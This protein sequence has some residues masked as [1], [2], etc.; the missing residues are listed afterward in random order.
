M[1]PEIHRRRARRP[2]EPRQRL[3]PPISSG[4]S[5]PAKFQSEWRRRRPLLQSNELPAQFVGKFL[6]RAKSIRRVFGLQFFYRC[7]ERFGKLGI[8]FSQSLRSVIANAAQHCHRRLAA[9]RRPAGT[10]RIERAAQAKQIGAVI[11]RAALGLLGRH[12]FRRAGRGAGLRQTGVIYG[13]GQAEIGD[14]HAFNAVV[15]QDIGR[16]DIAMHEA[17][18]MSGRQTLGCLNADAKNFFHVL[19]TATPQT[20]LQRRSADEFHH[21]IRKP[22]EFIHREDRHHVLVADRRRGLG[23]AGKPFPCGDACCKLRRE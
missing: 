12:V 20:I 1:T 7:D 9:K 16:L 15:Q 5:V 17:L 2:R 22:L 18:G 6:C 10:Q 3:P 4:V 11:D 21:E 14:L 8:D 23:F 19:R 13:S